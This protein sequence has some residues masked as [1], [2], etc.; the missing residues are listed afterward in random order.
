[1][2]KTD[3]FREAAFAELNKMGE[4]SPLSGAFGY[5]SGDLESKLAFKTHLSTHDIQ[6]S[7]KHIQVERTKRNVEQKLTQI[8][9]DLGLHSRQ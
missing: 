7:C 1:M 2:S 5:A 6:D 8:V 4:D 3:K 9:K